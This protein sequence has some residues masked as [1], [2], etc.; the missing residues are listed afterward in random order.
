M[1]DGFALAG[2][3]VNKTA[4]PH[5]ET[6]SSFSIKD[7]VGDGFLWAVPRCRR[8]LER[9]LTRRFGLPDANKFNKMIVPKTTLRSC[10][11]CGED[12]EVGVLCRKNN[13]QYIFVSIL[14]L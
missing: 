13:H 2:V 14:R 11:V 3:A 8:T 1:T 10:N 6:K 5:S 4:G 9:R 12:H 7:I